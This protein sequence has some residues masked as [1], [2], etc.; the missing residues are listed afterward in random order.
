MRGHSPCAQFQRIPTSCALRQNWPCAL[1][2][3]CYL[4]CYASAG[5]AVF[6]TAAQ[7][8]FEEHLHDMCMLHV[9][10]DG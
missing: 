2:T 4:P 9:A 8:I 5:L 1:S 10:V 3:P 7:E 6:D